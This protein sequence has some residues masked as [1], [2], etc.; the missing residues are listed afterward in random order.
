[1]RSVED[2]KDIHKGERCFIIGTGPSLRSTNLTLL[3]DEI[4][5]G[6]NGLFVGLE[7]FGIKPRYWGFSDPRT[8]E[9][10][11]KQVFLLDTTIF[12][13]VGARE[14]YLNNISQFEE[15]NNDP[16]V[17]M[18]I[19][20]PVLVPFSTDLTQGVTCGRTVV[21][22]VCLQV[23]YYMGFNRVY[24]VGCDCDYSDF[25]DTHFYRNPFEDRL[26]EVA[27][28]LQPKRLFAYQNAKEVFESDGREIINCTVGGKLEVFKRETLEEVVGT[29][30]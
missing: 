25:C 16:I 9:S 14:W 22:D 27:E 19:P 18:A 23:V 28:S 3:N 24:L 26:A 4:T 30:R 8:I 15:F 20:S 21:Y 6:V 7:Y 10:Y 12:L 17:L 2:F 5:F 13:A 29:V 1:M 11:Y